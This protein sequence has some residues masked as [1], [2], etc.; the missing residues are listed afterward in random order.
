MTRGELDR[1]CVANSFV[2][3]GASRSS[4]TPAFLIVVR[5]LDVNA[6]A[7][8]SLHQTSYAQSTDGVLNVPRRINTWLLANGRWLRNPSRLRVRLRSLSL[9]LDP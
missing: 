9:V 2:R 8:R 4:R 6:A 1:V 3:Q 5:L 7:L